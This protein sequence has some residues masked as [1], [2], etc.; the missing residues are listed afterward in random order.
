MSAAVTHVDADA[1]AEFRAGLVTGRRG[2]R[3]AAHLAGCDRCAALDGELAGASV[4]LASV[5]A[6]VLPDHVAQRLDAALAA[7]VAARNDPERAGREPSPEPGGHARRAAHRGFR[8]PSLRVLAPIAAA[9]AVVLA[10]GGY[11]LSL[12]AQGPGN[13]VTASS[14]GSAA[15]PVAGADEPGNRAAAP[16]ASGHA[17][18]SARS[19]LM[20]PADFTVVASGTDFTRATLEHDLAAELRVPQAEAGAEKAPST[21]L[22]ACVQHVADGAGLV[23]VLS[24]RYDGDP[25]IVIVA[26]TAHGEQAWVA[27]PDCAV[28]DSTS[29]LP[30]NLRALGS[31]HWIASQMRG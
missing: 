4:L 9:A 11:G 22:R 5:P 18:A 23:R 16:L 2:A 29:L 21:Q 19:E 13:Q 27:S 28:L 6:P 12:I 25:A 31:V 3:I 14:A 8:L 10:A 17:G 30:G 20:S 26:R 1:L 7:E 24:A 15:K